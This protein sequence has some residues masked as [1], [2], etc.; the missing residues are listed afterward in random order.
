MNIQKL[1]GRYNYYAETVTKF[2]EDSGLILEDES[3][4]MEMFIR[5]NK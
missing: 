2:M 3:P 1:S 4:D 5:F